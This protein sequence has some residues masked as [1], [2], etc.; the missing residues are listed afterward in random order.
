MCVCMCVCVFVRAHVCACVHLC[1]CV[2]EM[3]CDAHMHTSLPLVRRNKRM[4]IPIVTMKRVDD[5]ERLVDHLPEG[6]LGA[7]V[8]VMTTNESY[9]K[10]P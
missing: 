9:Q 1:V 5:A 10:V 6:E 8:V 3:S 7:R 4:V 2:C